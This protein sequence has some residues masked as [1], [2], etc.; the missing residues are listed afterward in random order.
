V[1]HAHRQLRGLRLDE[2]VAVAVAADPGAETDEAR[3]P[4]AARRPIDPPHR[5]LQIAVDLG[6]RHEQ[7]LPKEVETLAHL[8]GD[9]GLVQ[10]HVVGLPQDLDLGDDRLEPLLQLLL[11]ELAPMQVL[12]HQEDAAKGLQDGAPLGLGGVGGEHRQI[13]QVLQQALEVLG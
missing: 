4:D 11:V 1:V 3:H 10:A 6:D 2:G 12:G 5:P 9:L 8:V 13:D 7:G